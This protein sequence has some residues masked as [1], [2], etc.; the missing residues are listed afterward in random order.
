MGKKE[1]DIDRFLKKEDFDPKEFLDG[2]ELPDSSGDMT[3]DE[4][5]A[6]W[7]KGA[8]AVD[9]SSL[10]RDDGPWHN[11][12]Y[13]PEPAVRVEYTDADTDS[14]GEAPSSGPKAD[15]PAKAG[16]DG[17]N[18]AAESTESEDAPAESASSEKPEKRVSVE[19]MVAG[20]V[21]SVMEQEEKL[22][23]EAQPLTRRGLFSRK[24][25]EDTEPFFTPPP[26]AEKPEEKE[27]WEQEPERDAEEVTR[28]AHSGFARIKKHMG[29]MYLLSLVMA[30]ATV[31]DYEGWF[32][33]I[34]ELTSPMLSLLLLALTLI[35]CVVG[36]SVFA[37]GF[38]ALRERRI[39]PEFLISLSCLVAM[40]DCASAYFLPDRCSN[41][42]FAPITV[43][44]LTMTM[45]GEMLRLRG[46]RDSCHMLSYGKDP[47]VVCGIGGGIRKQTCRTD[48]FV[49]LSERDSQSRAWYDLLLPVVL[50]AGIVF[51]FLASFGQ[52]RPDDFFWCWSAILTASSSFSF[53][54]AF[55][56]PLAKM[57]ARLKKD[58]CAVA[59][60][61]G[62][63]IIGRD[64]RMILT[65]GDLFP[66]GT[67][68]LNGMRVYAESPETAISHA[69]SLARES[70]SGLARIF[71]ELLRTQG[72]K[73]ES[74][75]DFSF[76]RE[77]GVAATINGEEVILGTA[78][79]MALMGVRLPKELKMKT[80]VLLAVDKQLT[81]I[82]AVK[83]LPSDN[84]DAAI[85][86]VMRNHIHPIFAVRDMNITPELIRRKFKIKRKYVF[87]ELSDRIALSETETENPGYAA[88]L[89]FREGL[90]PYAE[91]VIASKRLVGAVR[92]GTGIAM[93]GSVAGALLSFYIAFLGSADILTPLPMLIFLALLAVPSAIIADWT[94]R[95]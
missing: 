39:A 52:S 90:M 18:A 69:A 3:V 71:D 36:S 72:G 1:M 31:A 9:E 25:M 35:A 16:G 21:D 80:A 91:T 14:S 57:A 47:Y 32:A 61:L 84:V 88:G 75:D 17:K 81:A 89:I 12:G 30:A 28:E 46:L 60:Y 45:R 85:R 87:L 34:P 24:K 5:L 63:E 67:V 83:Y 27:E 66:P 51:A 93:F 42:P 15:K 26:P 11:E 74:L 76:Y 20:V 62:A 23:E 7:G 59:G 56:A 73:Y 70:G 49:R 78:D 86:M 64:A 68:I 6:E 33:Y 19:N 92:A 44:A 53:T 13:S 37:R 58:G 38:G 40:A 2:I 77:G 79:F 4:I 94:H 43:V 8:S 95:Y 10:P 29:V 54:Y 65:D 82:F 48:G 41:M 50:A 22:R 55:G